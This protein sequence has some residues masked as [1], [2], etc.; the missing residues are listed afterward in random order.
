[1]TDLGAFVYITFFGVAALWLYLSGRGPVR[2]S[3]AA[4]DQFQ[5]PED[6]NSA[7]I[8]ADVE[9]SNPWLLSHSASK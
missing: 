6:S 5:R 8:A 7:S 1:M 2:G 4:E 9:E 3:D